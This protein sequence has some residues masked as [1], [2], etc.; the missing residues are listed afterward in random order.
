MQDFSS[1]SMMTALVIILVIEVLSLL[2]MVMILQIYRSQSQKY[3]QLLSGMGGQ[4]LWGAPGRVLIPLYTVLT[5]IATVVT[6]LLFLY[7]PHI[8]R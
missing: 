3:R 1:P 4:D 5:V 6:V 8:L 2:F 7:Q